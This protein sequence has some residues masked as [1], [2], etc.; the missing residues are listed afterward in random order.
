MIA[1]LSLLFS[2]LAL[3]LRPPFIAGAL[4]APVTVMC[5]RDEYDDFT[6]RELQIRC[7]ARS[8]RANGKREELLKRLRATPAFTNLYDKYGRPVP[9]DKITN[10]GVLFTRAGKRIDGAGQE[11]YA[12]KVL[13]PRGQPPD[14]RQKGRVIR[15]RENVSAPQ[16]R[17]RGA[18]LASFKGC[19]GA[20]WARPYAY[21]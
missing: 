21:C 20:A 9:P 2:S 3:Q 12:A 1:P 16:N 19:L 11:A 7:T 5:A 10:K 6:Y 4:R 13:G 8:L 17:L 14:R 15:A 18:S